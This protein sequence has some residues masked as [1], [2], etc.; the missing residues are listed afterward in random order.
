MADT[1]S[2][3]PSS[4][5][6]PAPRHKAMNQAS[7]DQP[8]SSGPAK[9]SSNAPGVGSTTPALVAPSPAASVT[10]PVPER[11]SLALLGDLATLAAAAQ[12]RGGLPHQ[13]ALC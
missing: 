5:P 11:G 4:N 9:T 8:D 13:P 12:R 10:V 1:G 7:I 2:I 6:G 3:D